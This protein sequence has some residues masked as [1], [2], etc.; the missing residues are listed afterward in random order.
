MS[1]TVV[2]LAERAIA[3]LER[4]AD[5]AERSAKT[6]ERLTAL[7]DEV[8]D[9]GKGGRWLAAKIR[10]QVAIDGDVGVFGEINR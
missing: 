2:Q 5:A 3:A 10:G 9:N 4:I 7:F 6:N 1:A 8:S